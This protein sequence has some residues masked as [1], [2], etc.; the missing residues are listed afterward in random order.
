MARVA[1]PMCI[2][3]SANRAEWGLALQMPRTTFFSFIMA[4]MKLVQRALLGFICSS[5]ILAACSDRS[6]NIV[7]PRG[8]IANTFRGTARSATWMVSDTGLVFMGAREGMH[9]DVSANP[10]LGDTGVA[11]FMTP[12]AIRAATQEMEIE[13]PASNLTTTLASVGAGTNAGTTK[14]RPQIKNGVTRELGTDAAGNRFSMQASPG[15]SR[16]TS[17]SSFVLYKNGE[18]TNSA[19]IRW[20]SSGN[21]RAAKRMILLALDRTTGSPA[22][23]VDVQYDAI[24]TVGAWNVLKSGMGETGNALVELVQP[25][26]LHAATPDEFEE[27]PCMTEQIYLS[28]MTGA[29]T[30]ATGVALAANVKKI[31]S[32][33]ESGTAEAAFLAALALCPETGVMCAAAAA[34]QTIALAKAGIAA[35]YAAAQYV[36]LS[37]AALA[38]FQAG[39]ALGHYQDCQARR[40][41]LDDAA[42]P[43]YYSAPG[44]GEGGGD[45]CETEWWI[46]YNGGQTW[47]YS[48]STFGACPI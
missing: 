4:F 27:W 6:S 48:Y 12:A 17:V 28:A 45:N 8:G 26:A 41:A 39:V 42:N 31:E 38:S 5:V 32:A 35:A 15:S 18:A 47:A 21:A 29:T 24:P 20:Q 34:L 1:L 10:T 30:A 46:S 14:I 3:G 25:D 11:S 44:G 23:V 43:Q 19:K 9:W 13:A 2:A 16:A 33:L 7:G 40:K 22:M 37:A 36:A